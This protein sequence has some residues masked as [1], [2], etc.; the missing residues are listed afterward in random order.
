ML[1]KFTTD[2]KPLMAIGT[3]GVYSDTGTQGTWGD[4]REIKHGAGPLTKAA[5]GLVQQHASVAGYD[6]TFKLVVAIAAIGAVLGIV[7]RRNLA[8]QSAKAADEQAA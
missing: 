5:S 2:G 7:L 8:A 4:Y 3:R 1:T 6:D